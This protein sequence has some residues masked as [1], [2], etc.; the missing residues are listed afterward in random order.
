MYPVIDKSECINSGLC[1]KRYP[2][3]N[4]MKINNHPKVYACY[5]LDE[6]I[7]KESSSGGVFTLLTSRVLMK[8]ELYMVLLLM[9][10][11]RLSI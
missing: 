1:E 9:I 3:L 10:V 11:S 4:D 5:N 8:V 6:E 2:I 7:R